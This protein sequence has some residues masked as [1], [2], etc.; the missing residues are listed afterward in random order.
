MK[1]YVNYLLILPAIGAVTLF[2]MT[3]ALSL[4]SYTPLV[5]LESA[6]RMTPAGAILG[7]CFSIRM[8]WRMPD[9]RSDLCRRMIEGFNAWF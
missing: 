5:A 6:V 8:L 1:L 3:L 2:A 4:V 7:L 9:V